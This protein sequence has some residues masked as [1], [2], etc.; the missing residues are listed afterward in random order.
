M[1]HKDKIKQFKRWLRFY[2]IRFV[3]FLITRYPASKLPKIKQLLKKAFHLFF[4]KEKVK[5]MALLPKEFEPR[6]HE[7]LDKMMDNQILTLLEVFFYEKLIKSNPNYIKVEGL[8]ILE[9]TYK[10]HGRFII[11]TAHFGSWELMGYTLAKLGYNMNAIAREQAD[12]Q[13][14]KFMNS[15]RENRNV[16]VIMKN[17]IIESIKKLKKGEIVGL[18]S[19]LNAREWGYQTT[20]FGKKASFYNAPVILSM[21]AK[22]PLIP[23]FVERQKDGT[24]LIRFEKPI[25]WKKG[26]KMSEKIRQYVERYESEF[27]RRPDLWCWFHPRYDHAEL[28]RVD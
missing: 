18:L 19:D 11:L 3:V 24:Q 28:G 14:T 20:F 10:K 22:A 25:E 2:L 15:F 12:N 5:A 21:R 27:R 6:K 23:S 13:M 7:I 8:E 9:E 17:N 16:K 4:K 26:T 1:T